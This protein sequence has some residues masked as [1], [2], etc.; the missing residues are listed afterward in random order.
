MGSHTAGTDGATCAVCERADAFLASV[1]WLVG[2]LRR[3]SEMVQVWS[4]TNGSED[5][6]AE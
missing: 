6:D 3:E 5:Y 1:D 2:T 4:E